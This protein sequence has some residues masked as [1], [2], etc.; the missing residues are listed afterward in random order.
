[1]QNRPPMIVSLRRAGLALVIASLAAVVTAQPPAPVRLRARH[2]VPAANVHVPGGEALTR[3]AMPLAASE[4]RHLLIQFSGR[5][6]A[7]DLAGL[8]AAGALPLRY[9]PE[10]TVAVSAGPS[11]DPASLARARWVGELAPADKLSVDSAS[12]LARDFPA[13]PLTVIEFHPDAT[14]AIVAERLGAAGTA[15]VPSKAL[16]GYMAAIP[17]DRTAIETLAADDTVA[18]IY[19]GTTALISSGA[20]MCEGLLSPEGVVANYATVGEGWDGSGLGTASL[21]YYLLKGSSDLGPSLQAGEIAR[22]LTAWGRYADVRWRPAAAPNEARSA[23][24]LWG[25]TDHGDGFPFSPETLAHAFFPSPLSSESLAG[26]IHF[27]DTYQWGVGDPALYDIFSVA[28]HES[29]HSLGLEHSSNPAAVMYPIYS[30]ILQGPADEDIHAIQTLYAQPERGVLPQGWADVAVGAAGGQ[31]VEQNGTYALTAAGRDVW[32]SADELR[33]VSRTLTGDGDITAHIDSLDAVQ[34]WTKAGVMI[35]RSADPGAPQAFLLVSG[36]KGIAFQRRSVQGGLTTSTA[37]G[38]GTAPR[39]LWL[40]RRGNLISAYTAP[41]DGG[42]RF[43]GS[44]TIEMEEQVLAG[45][46][47]SSHD[48][49]AM[50]KAVF[51]SVS[52]AAAPA[53]AH[54]DVGAVGVKGSWSTSATSV[55]LAGAGAD[56]WGAA[57]AFHFAWFPLVGNGEIVARV[58]SVQNVNAW[59]KAGVMIRESRDP[60]S[61]HAFMLVS[62]GKGYAFQRRTT[63]G[64][65]SASTAAGL[66]TAPQWVKLRR[67]GDLFT[68]F[69]SSDGVTWKAAGSATIPMAQEVLAGLAVSSHVS[70]ATSRAVFDTVQVR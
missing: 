47:L 15:A 32:G 52:V 6:T 39:W 48:P 68:A 46:A 9:V 60:G 25:G 45:L 57:D 22:A 44:A 35:R 64:G 42:W 33:F 30:G 2:F 1:L 29:G 63:Q 20:L 4:R 67:S 49:D 28:L 62:A 36:G 5:I 43:V 24:V 38:A 26:D 3:R 8:R 10:N 65:P 61:P 53:W 58:A 16:P 59:S 23:T 18:W 66:G 40:S 70:T 56:I 19:P 50:A 13:Y 12:D 31:A 37:G 17:T 41:N 7:Q 34:A 55:T 69:R 54:A 11:F 27:N 21:S 51:S 14:P